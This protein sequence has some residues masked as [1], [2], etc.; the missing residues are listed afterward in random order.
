MHDLLNPTL[1]T[2]DALVARFLQR[3]DGMA[4]DR[5]FLGVGLAVACFVLYFEFFPFSGAR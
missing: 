2:F 5:L 1:V 4:V 3:I